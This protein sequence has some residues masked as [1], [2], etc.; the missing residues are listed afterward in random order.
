MPSLSANV[1]RGT[2]C[3]TFL[4][5]QMYGLFCFLWLARTF[6]SWLSLQKNGCMRDCRIVGAHAL[7]RLRLDSDGLA[8]QTRNFCN[9]GADR[10][11]VRADLGSGKNQRGVEIHD[12]VACCAHALQR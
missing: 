7:G 8:G 9:A 1:P 2:F 11:G 6:G 4:Y 3:P 10:S 5:L 12:F